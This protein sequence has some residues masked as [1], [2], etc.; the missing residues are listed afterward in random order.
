VAGTPGYLRIGELSRRT[1]VSPELLRAWEQRY[2]VLEPTRSE[3]GFRLYSDAD[4]ARVRRMKGLIAEGISAAEA[5]SRTLETSPPPAEPVT[6]SRS[7][8]G[9]L[10]QEL[11]SALDGM[12]GER[13]HRAFDRILST[14]SVDALMQEVLVPYLHDL[15]DRWARGEVSIAHEHF[16]SNLIRGRLMGIARD[17]GAVDGPSVVLACPPGEAHD[18]GLIMFG[19]EIARLGWRV[20]FLGADTPVET[21]ANV[22]RSSRPELVVLASTQSGLLERQAQEIRSLATLAPVAIAGTGTPRLVE[23]LGARPLGGD[24]VEAARWIALSEKSA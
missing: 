14:A 12:D 2:G 20:T 13:A 19:I 21:L 3:G 11:T 15:G 17:W 16:A 1:G 5:A 24:P 6:L 18:L 4:A 22:V 8:I 7:A 10:R 9:D 23:L